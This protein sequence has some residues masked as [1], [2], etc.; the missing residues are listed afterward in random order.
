M[1]NITLVYKRISNLYFLVSAHYMI[2]VNYIVPAR[3]LLIKSVFC[4][5]RKK[6]IT[7]KAVGQRLKS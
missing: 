4:V 5:E 3:V 2:T 7:N 6:E 1:K